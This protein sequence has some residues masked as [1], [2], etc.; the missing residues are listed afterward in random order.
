MLPT[1]KDKP[2]DFFSLYL[3]YAGIGEV[4]PIL[5]RWGAL[6]TAAVLLGRRSYFTFGNQRIFPNLYVIFM[7]E[8]ASKKSTAINLVKKLLGRTGFDKFAPSETSKG[9]FAMHL[10]GIKEVTGR[11]AEAEALEIAMAE[12]EL[13]KA[14]GKKIG[15]KVSESFI[16][17]GELANFLGFANFD[18]ASFLGDIWD[19]DEVHE[20]SYKSA[21]EFKIHNPLV[22]LLGGN[23]FE[24]MMK[25]LPPEMMGQGFLSRCIF[26]YAPASKTKI[27]F[28]TGNNLVDDKELLDFLAYF[29]NFEGEITLD[30]SAKAVLTGIYETWPGIGDHRFKAYSGRRFTQLLKL[31]MLEAICA[32]RTKITVADA[33]AANTW[34]SYT[35]YMMPRALGEYGAGKNSM[36]SNAVMNL[37]YAKPDILINAMQIWGQTS[38]AFDNFQG[39]NAVLAGLLN[40]KKLVLDNGHFRLMPSRMTENQYVRLSLFKGWV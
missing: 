3:T 14:T 28:P 35:E 25:T 1:N 20:V 2:H 5:H 30:E 37:F 16:C 36:G 10:A 12:I 19:K 39:F 6:M 18:F 9:K 8:S 13:E 22:N 17:A 26:V 32:R 40:A 31:C 24:G 34:L 23:T 33:M 27:A 21:G 38:S 11:R 4:S 7:G 29:S 15:S